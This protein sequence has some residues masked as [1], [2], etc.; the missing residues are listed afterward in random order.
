MAASGRPTPRVPQCATRCA[1]LCVRHRPC[2]DGAFAD[3]RIVWVGDRVLG[4]YWR[5]GGDGFR[6]N[7]ARGGEA[8]FNAVPTH[9]IERVGEIARRLSIDHA[10]FNVMVVDGHPW[11]LE[12]N[13]PFGNEALQRQGI[14]VEAAMFDYLQR[15]SPPQN[16]VANEAGVGP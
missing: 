10:G 15:T 16:F 13:T 9:A 11:L 1:G 12:S 2:G 4:A 8:D 7:I 3:L 6:H 14:R 5:R